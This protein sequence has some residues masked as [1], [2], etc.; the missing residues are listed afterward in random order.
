[1]RSLIAPKSLFTA[2][3][4]LFAVGA[5]L[6]QAHARCIPFDP[7]DVTATGGQ[8][9]LVP[10]GSGPSLE[11]L[12]ANIVVRLWACPGEPKGLVDYPAQD[13]WIEGSGTG[14]LAFCAEGG[15]ADGPTDAGGLTTFSRALAGGGWDSGEMVVHAGGLEFRLSGYEFVSPDIDGDLEV[16][17]VDFKEFGLDYSGS[18]PRSDLD[19]DGRVDLNDF[20]VM[21]RSF[22]ARCR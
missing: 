17:I 20:L 12:G 7:G 21:S 2:L 14:T 3:A 6:S 16:D 18:A 9:L 8:V 15:I 5:F 13:I 22:G 4:L 19:F 11:S 10:D 1:M